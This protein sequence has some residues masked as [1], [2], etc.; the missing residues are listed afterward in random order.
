MRDCGGGRGGM[1]R[2]CFEKDSSGVRGVWRSLPRSLTDSVT[3]NSLHQHNAQ[4]RAIIESICVEDAD[5]RDG[6]SRLPTVRRIHRRVEA[7]L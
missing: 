3:R 5:L 1:F 2:E 6:R 4:H 7:L